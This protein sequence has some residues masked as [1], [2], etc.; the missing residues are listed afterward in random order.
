MR[1]GAWI[2]GALSAGAP[3]PRRVAASGVWTAADIFTLTLRY[4]ETPFYDTFAFHFNG[5]SL[6][7]QGQCNVAFGEKEYPVVK[8]KVER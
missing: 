5:G 7:L 4:Y 3:S 1:R 2:E 8:G 6:L